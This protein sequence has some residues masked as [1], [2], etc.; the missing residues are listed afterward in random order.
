MRQPFGFILGA[1]VV[2]AI[3]IAFFYLPPLLATGQ[4]LTQ[5]RRW[6]TDPAAHPELAIAAGNRCG[7]APFVLP[8]DGYLGFG[9]GDSFR[10]GHRHQGLDIFGPTALN[11]TPVV[12][13]YDGYLTRE[14]DWKSAVII[15]HPKDPLVPS[16]QIWTYYAHMADPEGH[17]FILPG[18]P[19][20]THEQFVTAGTL[21]GYQ[22]DYSGDDSNPVG[23]HLHF[24]V[25][26]SKPDGGYKNELGIANTDD[27]I[28]YLGLSLKDGVWKC[29]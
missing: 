7:S 12:A 8:T 9:Y 11:Q 6:I 3:V 10:P 24:S 23:M 14:A 20:G 18:F 22:G 27:P 19:Q 25:V 1:L 2:A 28:P 21:L 4:K 16:G 17:S 26:Q 5:L 29:P 15:R 13:A